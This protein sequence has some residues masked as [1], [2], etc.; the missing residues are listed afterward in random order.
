MLAIKQQRAT[1]LS[2]GRTVLIE[3]AGNAAGKQQSIVDVIVQPSV[4]QDFGLNGIQCR[5][6]NLNEVGQD[7]VNLA[8]AVHQHGKTRSV[9]A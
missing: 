8:V 6:A 3:N 1:G 4:L 5:Q 2:H 9:A 7:L